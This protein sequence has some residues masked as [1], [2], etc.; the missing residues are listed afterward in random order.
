MDRAKR[1]NAERRV[2]D[3]EVRICQLEYR[4]L[5]GIFGISLDKPVNITQR[6]ESKRSEYAQESRQRCLVDFGLIDGGDT[7]V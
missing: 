5:V 2:N 6:L 4:K 7:L 3:I 1:N